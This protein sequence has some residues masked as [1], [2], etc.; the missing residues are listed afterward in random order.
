MLR[1]LSTVSFYAADL[2]AA[3]RW[4]TEL[5]GFPPY[6][7]VPGYIEFRIGDFQHEVGVIDSRYA[8]AGSAL[9]PAGAIVF[10]HVDD[11]TAALAKLLSLGAKEF[12]GIRDRGHGFVTASVVDPFG[13]ILG[14]MYNPHYLEVF[15]ATAGAKVG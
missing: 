15:G 2:Q 13:N 3:E 11:V 9:E 8:P 7:S 6:Y 4:Y 5:F 10:W 14:I 1:G 12:E